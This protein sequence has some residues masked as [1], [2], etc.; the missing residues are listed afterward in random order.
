MSSVNEILNGNPYGLRVMTPKDLRL[1]KKSVLSHDFSANG[2]KPIK[3]PLI[4]KI[5]RHLGKT[6][7]KQEE[8]ERLRLQKSKGERC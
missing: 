4:S 2:D 5:A 1:M 7:A 6:I 8:K 3:E